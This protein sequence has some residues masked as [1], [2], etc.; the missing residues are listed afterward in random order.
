[1]ICDFIT[2]NKIFTRDDPLPREKKNKNYGG[3]ETMAGYH[4]MYQTKI[5]NTL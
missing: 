2:R 1:M 3:G 4:W 5:I